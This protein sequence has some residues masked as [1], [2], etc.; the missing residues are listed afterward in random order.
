MIFDFHVHS[1]YSDGSSTLDEIFREAKAHNAAAIAITDHDTVLGLHEENALS[2]KYQIPF[3]SGV[4]LTAVEGQTKFHVLA[5]NV[6]PDSI[7]LKEYSHKLLDF[8]IEKSKKQIKILQS[9]GVSIEESEFFKESKGGPLYRAKLLSTL[10]RHGYFRSEDI[11][12]QL[13]KYFGR[14]GLCY[15]EDEYKYPDFQSIYRLI[16][17][18]NGLIVLA[19]PAKIKGK[20]YKLYEELIHSSFLDG[21]ELYHPSLNAEVEKEL[22]DIIKEKGLIFTGG[23]DYHG[24][25]NKLKTPLCGI[26]LPD[27]VYTNL[28][29]FLKKR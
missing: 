6:D 23:S 14:G 11:M 22:D 26:N 19:H 8:L 12:G 27:V 9:M 25:Y 17:K 24:I 15:V 20:N 28:Y 7:E 29:P 2:I 21:I 1:T 16:K 4:E 3:V 13:Q 18:N 5:Y 10:S